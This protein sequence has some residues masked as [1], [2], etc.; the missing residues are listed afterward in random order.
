MNKDVRT[1]Y[2]DLLIIDTL[3]IDTHIIYKTYKTTFTNENKDANKSL[4]LIHLHLFIDCIELIF[5]V[6]QHVS[7]ETKQK[8]F[9]STMVPKPNHTYYSIVI[10]KTFNQYN[11]MRHDLLF[12]WNP[13]SQK[14]K[15]P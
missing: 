9:A 8:C 3:I 2:L 15:S 4:R 12:G 5:H 11:N 6:K 13:S 7:D 10:L 1:Y 14:V